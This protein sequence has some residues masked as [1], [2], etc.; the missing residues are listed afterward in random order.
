MAR[1]RF[2]KRP[3][4]TTARLTA[5]AAPVQELTDEAITK[6]RRDAAMAVAWRRLA[7][8]VSTEV[9]VEDYLRAV[10]VTA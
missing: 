5:E 1:M 9:V 10:G 7:E 8:P 3:T 6:I 4:P 2:R